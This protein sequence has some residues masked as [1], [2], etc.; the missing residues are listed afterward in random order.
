MTVKYNP[1]FLQ[2]IP[3][4]PASPAPGY[5]GTLTLVY[6]AHYENNKIALNPKGTNINKIKW[7]CATLSKSYRAKCLI[8]IFYFI[9]STLFSKTDCSNQ[10]FDAADE[11]SL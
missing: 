8:I 4:Y 11:K 10:D 1:F 7:A 6:S 9:S 2:G 3:F 5:K